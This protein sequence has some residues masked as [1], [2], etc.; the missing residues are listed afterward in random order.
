[1]TDSV[2]LQD[3]TWEEVREKLDQGSKT[4]LLPFGSTEQHGPHLPCGTDTM[5]AMTLAQDAAEKTGILAAPPLWFGWSPHHMVLPG[6]ITIRPDI[7]AEMAFD[8][9]TSLHHHGFEKFVLINGHRIVNIT[10]MQMAGERAKRELAAK[11][12]IFDPAYMSKTITQ[13]LGWGPVGHAEEIEGSHM[14]YR[15]P[16]LVK[17]DR[18]IDNPHPKSEL[19]S[20]DPSYT[21]DT[22]CYLPS[23]P[24]EM[25]H[26]T[27]KSKGTTG[28]PSKASR[29]GGK[30]Y[31]DHLVSR[32]V[33]VITLLERNN[34]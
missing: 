29:D 2:W 19:Y 6:T 8:I 14:M 9:I 13:G 15:Y 3:L 12:V 5:V 28:E 32:L 34:P 22:L 20:V 17:M 16:D 1:M 30:I 11:V 24:E 33:E 31:H 7:L 18:A 10:W 27:L 25:K 23:S 21:E 4:I 26:L